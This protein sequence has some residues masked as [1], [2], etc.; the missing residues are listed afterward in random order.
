MTAAL[1][2]AASTAV[3]GLAGRIL[4]STLHS[5]KYYRPQQ[6]AYTSQSCKQQTRLLKGLQPH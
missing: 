3:A 4:R 1:A 5:C 2:A 6:Q